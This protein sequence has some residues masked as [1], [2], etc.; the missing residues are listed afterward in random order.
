[1]NLR[2]LA[3]ATLRRTVLSSLALLAILTMNSGLAA[4]QSARKTVRKVVERVEPEYP[5]FFRSG[6][7]EGRI[8]AQATV[9]PS[10]TV[11]GVEIKAG[12]PMFATFVSKALMRWKFAPGPDKTVEE[13]VF[14]FRVTPR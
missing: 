11:S 3:I 1:M 14:N 13:V 8:V 5:D 2:R 7:F 10:G 9:Q 6:H 4:A 12:N